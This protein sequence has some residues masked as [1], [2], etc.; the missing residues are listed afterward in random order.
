MSNSLRPHGLQHA[1]LLCRSLSP[2]L[3]S[4]S[5]A[6]SQWCYLT[7]SSSVTSFSFAFNLSQH[8]DLFQWVGSSHQ[9]AKVL[10][11]Q[12]QRTEGEATH[13][14]L[15]CVLGATR[16]RLVP[17]ELVFITH[18]DK[19]SDTTPNR[20]MPGL[21]TAAAFWLLSSPRPNYELMWYNSCIS[22]LGRNAQTTAQL[23]SSHTLVK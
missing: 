6:L 20:V 16:W 19:L 15:F 9:V 11:L 21:F 12:L 17:N 8:Q 14:S 13:I 10:E 5:Y 18:W 1:R 23:H 4:D 2:R 3:G 22:L 7:I